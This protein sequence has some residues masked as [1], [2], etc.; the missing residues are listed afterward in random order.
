MYKRQVKIYRFFPF[1]PNQEDSIVDVQFI[2]ATGGTYFT[3][4]NAIRKQQCTTTEA[5]GETCM[6][7]H[8]ERS[9]ATES[10]GRAIMLQNGPNAKCPRKNAEDTN[11]AIIPQCQ[12][13][14]GSTIIVSG[15]AR[16]STLRCAGKNEETISLNV[17]TTTTP[18]ECKLDT[19]KGLEKRNWQFHE[20]KKEEEVE[21]IKP[22]IH[23]LLGTLSLKDLSI[24]C[25]LYTSPSPRD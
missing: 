18:G 16:T 9:D 17:G 19:T 24:I 11:M 2:V 5:G 7:I 3:S 8:F 21:Y 15:T 1:L 10:C 25:L 4:A 23:P 12:K 20:P 13:L 14:K 22:P 6:R